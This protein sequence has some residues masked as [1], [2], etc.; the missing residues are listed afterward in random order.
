MTTPSIVNVTN[1]PTQPDE[2]KPAVSTCGMGLIKSTLAGDTNANTELVPRINITAMIGAEIRTERPMLFAGAFVSPARIAMYS[3]P[4]SAPNASLL[5]TL[6]LYA[7]IVGTCIANGWY[8]LIDPRQSAING[9]RIK[10]ANVIINIK[11]PALWT[12]LPKLNPR[13]AARIIA[14][15]KTKLTAKISF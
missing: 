1:F 15:T 13:T 5:N 6:M 8:S 4:V 7:D 3:K 12:H 11:P 10:V 14:T 9:I 2:P